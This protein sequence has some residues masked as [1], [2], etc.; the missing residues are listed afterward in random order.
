MTFL[1][2]L[3]NFWYF[4]KHICMLSELECRNQKVEIDKLSLCESLIDDNIDK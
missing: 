2:F 1:S 4:K 3:N